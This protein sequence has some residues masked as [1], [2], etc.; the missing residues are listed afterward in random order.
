MFVNLAKQDPGRARQ[1]S[2]DKFLQTTSKPFLGHLYLH[3]LYFLTPRRHL[4]VTKIY[5]P[6]SRFVAKSLD[7]RVS[8]LF[9]FLSCALLLFLPG[10]RSPL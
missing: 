9:V 3:V 10:C 7:A 5:Y 8:Y 6:G 2:L 4:G 1:K